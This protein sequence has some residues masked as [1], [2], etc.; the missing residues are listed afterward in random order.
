[1]VCHRRITPCSV[2]VATSVPASRCTGPAP[3]ACR[4]APSTAGPR[5][6]AATELARINSEL[7][8]SAYVASHH[9][10]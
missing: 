6:S 9:L 7:E 4:G 2:R 10:R 3:S 8:Q 5:S 1:M